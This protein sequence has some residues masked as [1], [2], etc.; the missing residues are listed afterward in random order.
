MSPLFYQGLGS[1]LAV[2]TVICL[3]LWLT[4]TRTNR[5]VTIRTNGGLGGAALLSGLIWP[6][7]IIGTIGFLG[8]YNYRRWRKEKAE[9]TREVAGSRTERTWSGGVLVRLPRVA[10]A[11]TEP[12]LLSPDP[13]GRPTLGWQV[14]GS[15]E[16]YGFSCQVGAPEGDGWIVVRRYAND[17]FFRAGYGHATPARALFKLTPEQVKTIAQG[18]IQSLPQEPTPEPKRRTAWEHLNDDEDP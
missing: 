17:I 13:P 2:G 5:G 12:A 16:D 14:H 11:H 8:F 4:V 18:L 6:L 3:C 7:Y 15:G 9:S 1:Y 10:G